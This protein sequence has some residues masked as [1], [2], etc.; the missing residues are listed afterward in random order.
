MNPDRRFGFR[1][2][3]RSLELEVVGAGSWCDVN[4]NLG[5]Y[6]GWRIVSLNE[7]PVYNI[8]EFDQVRDSLS[9]DV[10]IQLELLR[11][12]DAS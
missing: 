10:G 5:D 9:L 2:D 4:L 8:I 6:I 1:S 7:Q 12:E 3:T 11:P